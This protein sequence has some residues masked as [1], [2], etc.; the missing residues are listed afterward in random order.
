MNSDRPIGRR[1]R[2]LLASAARGVA[3]P[4]LAGAA[5]FAPDRHHTGP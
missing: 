2:A 3:I 1:V 5:I 4:N